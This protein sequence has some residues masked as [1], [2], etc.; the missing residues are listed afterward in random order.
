[1]F[2]RRGF[3]QYESEAGGGDIWAGSVYQP[4]TE[5][6]IAPTW[7][8]EWVGQYQP[9]IPSS[10]S[11]GGILPIL[12]SLVTG[13]AAV[14]SKFIQ[15]QSSKEQAK[16]VQQM[17]AAGTIP[18]GYTLSPT[19]QLVPIQT[20]GFSLGGNWPILA[21]VGIGAFLVMRGKKSG[22]GEIKTRRVRRKK[23]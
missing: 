6:T 1:M 16:T 14:G 5:V 10:I 11:S 22:P 9:S 12:T 20:A 3:G 23:K 21:I 2:L 7:V 17:R 13:A 15:L 19:G 18:A 4:E 8:K